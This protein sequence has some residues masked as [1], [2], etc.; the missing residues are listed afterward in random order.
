[1]AKKLTRSPRDGGI[2]VTRHAEPQF[3]LVFGS[4]KR[5]RGFM[6]GTFLDW[7][8]PPIGVYQATTAEEACQ[9]AAKDHGQM[10]TYFA[11]AGTPWGI[12]MMEAPARQLGRSANAEERMAQILD[13][14]DEN[15]QRIQELEAKRERERQQLE[16][17]HR[18]D[19]DR[20]AEL[21]REV[22]DDA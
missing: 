15:N 3:Y 17:E 1:M 18:P 21:E 7:S 9:A 4:L 2:S 19:P 14:M 10:A 13:K 16:R 22:L 6:G 12:D 20:I 11:V 5:P 8:Q